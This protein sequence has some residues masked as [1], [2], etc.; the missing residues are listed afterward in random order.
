MKNSE[1]K[2]IKAAYEVADENGK[3]MLRAL[4]P[5][6]FTTATADNRPVTE[7]IKTFEDACNELGTGHPFVKS[8]NGYVNHIHEDEMSDSDV[9][10]FLKLR[11]VVAA[12]NE[13][14]IPDWRNKVQRK[15][16][17]WFYILTEKEIALE[18]DAKCRVVGRA[19]CHANANGGLVCSFA[20]VVSTSSYTVYGARLAF[21]TK[22]LAEYCAKQFGELWAAFLLG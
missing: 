10:E 21:K 22:E 9:V 2:D 5:D 12:L 13:G 6:V 19:Y 20:S 17:P 11:I 1:L 16:Y 15:W 8:L 14:W 3:K 7:R 4:Y 18:E